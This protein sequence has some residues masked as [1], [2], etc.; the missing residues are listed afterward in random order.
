MAP[1]NRLVVG[2]NKGE[3]TVMRP[4]IKMRSRFGG[5]VTSN[6]NMIMTYR[7]TKAKQENLKDVLN[8]RGLPGDVL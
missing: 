2:E 7:L 3:Y 4:H 1:S 5:I 6:T 8:H